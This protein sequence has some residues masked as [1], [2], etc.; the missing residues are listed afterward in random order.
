MRLR[1][2][3]E[4]N[5][6]YRRFHQDKTVEVDVLKGLVDL[7]RLSPSAANLQPLKYILSCSKEIN[8][9]I[10]P[11]LSWAGYLKEWGGPSEGERPSAYIIILGDT[12]ISKDFGYDAGIASQSI[13]LGAV[14]LGLGGCIIGSIERDRLR[15][16][17]NIDERFEI[18][19]VI[20]LGRPKEKVVVEPFSGDIK[21]WRD[22]EGV[23]HVP[24]RPLREIILS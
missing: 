8:A 16:A 9:K 17:L 13:L 4:R 5:R 24:K 18:L 20:A 14:E 1:G 11:T 10:F 23:H 2:L 21:Y 6:S 15:S 12:T 19:L 22:R 3:I 7:A